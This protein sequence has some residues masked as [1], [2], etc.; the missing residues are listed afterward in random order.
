[1]GEGMSLTGRIHATMWEEKT[2]QMIAGT[3]GRID[4]M[5]VIGS[6]KETVVIE[7]TDA[8]FLPKRRRGWSR[9]DAKPTKKE[10]SP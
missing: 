9:Y 5:R 7:I 4:R 3:V 6:D 1:M 2:S 8:V 10:K